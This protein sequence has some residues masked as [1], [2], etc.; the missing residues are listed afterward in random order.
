[1]KRSLQILLRAVGQILAAII[2]AFVLFTLVVMTGALIPHPSK[3]KGDKVVRIYV[4]SNGIHTDICMPTESAIYDWK[5]F[6]DVKDYPYNKRFEYVAMGWGDKGFYIDTPTWAD[7]TASTTINALFIPSACAMH[8][9]YLEHVPSESEMCIPVD[10]TIEGYI[11]LTDYI[12]ESFLLKDYEPKLIENA[13][14]HGTDHFYEANGRYH[15]LETC[16]SWTNG[17][18]KSAG[19]RTAKWAIFPETIIGFQSASNP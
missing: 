4:R 12:R 7:L 5:S 14:Y 19:V 2:T 3:Y 1:M 16:N 13:S 17:A 18:L 8:V 11:H 10:L 15:L 9:E 6:V